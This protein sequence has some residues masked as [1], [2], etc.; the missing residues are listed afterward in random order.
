MHSV[1]LIDNREIRSNIKVCTKHSAQCMTK[2]MGGYA[3]EYKSFSDLKNRIGQMEK[4]RISV[5]A[6][7]DAEVIKTLKTVTELELADCILVGDKVKIERLMKEEGLIRAEII[8]EP[9][10]GKAALE[11]AN[12]VRQGRADVLMKGL[13]NSS[14]F[15]KAVLDKEKGLK[16]GKTLSH[17][18]VFEVPNY[19]KLQFHTDGGMNL[20]PD[21]ITKKAIIDNS[22]EALRKIGVELPNVAVLTANEA[23]NPKMPSTVDAAEL[24]KWNNNGEFLQCIMEGPISMDVALSREA[25]LHK[26]IK[27]EISG[28]TDLFV[29]PNIDAGNMI[30]KTLLY[31]ANAKMAGVIL[32]AKSP[33]VMT[34]RA[35][36]AEGKLNSIILACAVS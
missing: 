20:Y 18:A 2:T 10:P 36:N 33:V 11:A 19:P 28:E 34:S 7:E 31:C 12:L 32:G 13:V 3:M 14:D 1:K 5:A 23:V 25:A 30:G 17:L 26:G 4:R 15:L 22:L 35:E 29:V 9:E 16:T 27:S 6:A 21:L 24:V 8:H